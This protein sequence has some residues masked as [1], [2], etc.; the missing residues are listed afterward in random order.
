MKKQ[1]HL[2]LPIGADGVLCF[3]KSNRVSRPKCLSLAACPTSANF[4]DCILRA[5]DEKSGESL[6]FKI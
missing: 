2:V 5:R 6:T 1:T 4:A 3:L